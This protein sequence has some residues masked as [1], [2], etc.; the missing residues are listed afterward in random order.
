MIPERSASL[1][2]RREG[3][4][5]RTRGTRALLRVPVTYGLGLI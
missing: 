1:L 3:V 2:W 5:D 4:R